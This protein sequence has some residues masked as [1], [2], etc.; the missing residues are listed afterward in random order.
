MRVNESHNIRSFKICD[1]TVKED[2]IDK[3]ILVRKC[4][5][6]R[7]LWRHGHMWKD[8][9]NM[10]GKE[11]E[12]EDVHWIHLAQDRVQWWA[13]VNMVINLQGIS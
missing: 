8:G 9:I 3:T 6:M 12:C 10:D 7:P 2:E 11:T 4:K 1:D 13:I 5:W